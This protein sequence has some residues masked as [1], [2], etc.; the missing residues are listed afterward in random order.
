MEPLAA[1]HPAVVIHRPSRPAVA[2]VVVYLASDEARMVNSAVLS[3]KL[4]QLKSEE[5]SGPRITRIARI[6]VSGHNKQ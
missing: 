6:L 5:Y 2:A 3:Q 4:R 1:D